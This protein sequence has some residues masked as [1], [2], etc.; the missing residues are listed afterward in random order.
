MNPWQM[1]QQIKHLLEQAA[2]SSGTEGLVFGAQ[3]SVVVWAGA[4]TEQVPPGFPFALV[5]ID[6]GAMDPDEPS[7]ISQGFSITIGQVV[8]GDR[9]GEFALIGGA[10]PD[11][12][13]SAGRG[14]LELA[15][16]VSDAIQSLTGADGAQI[17]VSGISTAPPSPLG[18]G[19][20]RHLAIAE[21]TLTGVCTSQEHYT[22]PQQIAHNGTVWSWVGTQCSSRYDFVTYRLVRKAGTSAPTSPSDGTVVYTGTTASFTGAATAGNT[23]AAFADYGS[24]G[25][26]AASSEPERGSYRVVPA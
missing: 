13:S 18:T 17:L 15:E 2:W 25:T 8:A 24:R 3:G 1:A 22:A 19:D 23:Y 16:R 6:A 5:G 4:P 12:G 9:L 7:L 21:L 20:R 26:T 10:A 11:L 14:V